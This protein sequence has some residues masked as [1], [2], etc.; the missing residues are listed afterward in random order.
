MKKTSFGIDD[1]WGGFTDFAD[2]PQLRCVIGTYV[3]EPAVKIIR[4]LDPAA[5]STDTAYGASF[6]VSS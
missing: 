6:F 5:G 4:N 3:S 1:V 2:G